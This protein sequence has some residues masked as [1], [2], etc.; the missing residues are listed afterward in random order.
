MAMKNKQENSPQ[1]PSAL[2][3]VWTVCSL[4][5]MRRWVNQEPTLKNYALAHRLICGP[6]SRAGF[7]CRWSVQ[8]T[9][10]GIRIW[11]DLLIE[12]RVCK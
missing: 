9:F 12:F 7:L 11:Q 5:W 10:F 1:Q 8:S 2:F 3:I 4:Y 6:I